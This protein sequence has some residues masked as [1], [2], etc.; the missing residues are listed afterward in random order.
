M[1]G[2]WD[3]EVDYA[4]HPAIEGVTVEIPPGTV[5]VV[6]GG[7]GAGKTTLLR[8]LVGQAPIS[9]GRVEVPAPDRIGY[10]NAVAGSWRDLSVAEN[11]AFVGR[12][13]GLSGTRLTA[14]ADPLLERAGLAA[15]PDRLAGQ[16]SGGMRRKLGFVLAMLAQ[17]ELLVLDE[18]TTGVDP[19]SR[20]GIWRLVSDAAAGGTAV[21]MATTYLDEGERSGNLVVLESGRVLVSGTPSQVIDSFG[22]VIVETEHPTR[23]QWSW[24][25]GAAFHEWFDE[26]EPVINS[27]VVPTSLED[28]VIASA[29]KRRTEARQ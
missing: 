1:F 13:Y 5:T 22:G 19:V 4:G 11:V 28:V 25:Y 14:V 21:I 9:G 3:L 12:A 29:L 10:L 20:T 16:L 2:S 18:P 23:P 7:D 6:V 24:R 15:V 17:P 8:A 27:S 26:A